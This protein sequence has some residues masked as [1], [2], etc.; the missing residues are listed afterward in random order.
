MRLADT[1]DTPKRMTVAGPDA[2]LH[3]A[4]IVQSSED[5]IISKDLG[6][7]I[8]SWNK[9]AERLFGW[10]AEE[11]VG[12]SVLTLIPADR[13]DEEPGIIARIQRGERIEHYETVRQ[14]KDGSLVDISLTVLPRSRAT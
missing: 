9:S 3:Y 6:G 10:Q 11:I 14:R 5:A 7:I 2:A 8:T 12:R 1:A 13:Y 4:A